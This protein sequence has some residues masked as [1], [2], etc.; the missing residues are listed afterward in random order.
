VITADT[1]MIALELQQ[2]YRALKE[3][4]LWIEVSS[5]EGSPLAANP[6]SITETNYTV[7]RDSGRRLVDEGVHCLHRSVL[8]LWVRRGPWDDHDKGIGHGERSGEYPVHEK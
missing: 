4:A 5:G 6:S 3:V 2:A 8:G 7:E 1:P